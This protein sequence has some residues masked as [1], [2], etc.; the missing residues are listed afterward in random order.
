MSLPGCC[1]VSLLLCGL[2]A[3][4]VL[5]PASIGGDLGPVGVIIVAMRSPRRKATGSRPR[6][7]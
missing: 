6:S 4:V 3:E 2:G 1:W 5:R 7:S